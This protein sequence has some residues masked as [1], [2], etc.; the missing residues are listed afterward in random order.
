MTA[1]SA[2]PQP[3]PLHCDE[4]RAIA[5]FAALTLLPAI[6]LVAPVWA[7][8]NPAMLGIVTPMGCAANDR[9]RCRVAPA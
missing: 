8:E 5:V 2:S 4:R 6:A 7:G 1:A 3:M 9:R